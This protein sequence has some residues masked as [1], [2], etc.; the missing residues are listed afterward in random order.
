MFGIGSVLMST[1]TKFPLDSSSMFNDGPEDL[2]AIEQGFTPL[3]GR[4]PRGVAICFEAIALVSTHLFVE[5]N[6]RV[7]WAHPDENRVANTV[8]CKSVSWRNVSWLI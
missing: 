7:S 4:R 5:G 3:D 2:G 8:D 1:S 6:T